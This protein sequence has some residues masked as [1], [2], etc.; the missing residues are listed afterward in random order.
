ME[1]AKKAKPGQQLSPHFT[2]GELA[3][4][5]CGR[6]LIQGELVSRL[7]ILHLP[8]GKPVL[9]NSATAAPPP[10]SADL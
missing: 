6:L 8:V 7:E 3:C 5:C 10:M 2:E 1:V 9:V 4:R